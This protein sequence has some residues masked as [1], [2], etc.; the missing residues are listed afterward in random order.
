MRETMSSLAL[1]GQVHFRKESVNRRPVLIEAVSALPVQAIAVV[2]VRAPGTSQV[3]AR[4]QCLR[5]IVESLQ[6][7]D[8]ARLVLDRTSGAA[9]DGRTLRGARRPEPFLTF[10]HRSSREEPMLWVADGVA[11]A[12]GARGQWPARLGPM[13]T[14]VITFP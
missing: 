6:E 14:G 11:W 9:D 5:A 8:V 12:V 2:A 10:E 7:R 13:L 1:H 4:R 3:E